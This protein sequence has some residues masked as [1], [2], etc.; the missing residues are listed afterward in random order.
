M[1]NAYSAHSPTVYILTY[2]VI[3]LVLMDIGQ[4]RLDREDIRKYLQSR[5]PQ[6]LNGLFKRYNYF[7]FSIA[8]GVLKEKAWAEEATQEIFLLLYKNIHRFDSSAESS[9][10]KA[11][12]R[13]VAKRMSITLYRKKKRINANEAPETAASAGSAQDVSDSSLTERFHPALKEALNEMPSKYKIPLLLFFIDE[14]SYKEIA[15]MLGITFDAVKSNIRT[16]RRWLERR[17]K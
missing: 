4:D 11:W 1:F 14:L 3:R 8:K 17:L 16:G 5:D 9:S 2:L 6:C 13:V 15:V 7:V 10:F 12:V